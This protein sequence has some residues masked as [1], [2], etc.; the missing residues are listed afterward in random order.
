LR[1]A[2]SKGP[3]RVGVSPHLRM[4]T[5]QV[6]EMSCFLFP[7]Y[8]ES[9]RWTKSK[10]PLILCMSVLSSKVTDVFLIYESVT[11]SMKDERRIT[12]EFSFMNQLPA[13]SSTN[14]E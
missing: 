2:L 10:N 12:H 14:E 8:L 11:S 6:S 1:L 7:N 13:D 4:E 5:D 3:N 9:G